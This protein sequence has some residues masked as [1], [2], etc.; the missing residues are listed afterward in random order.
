[1][2]PL[3]YFLLSGLL[4]YNVSCQTPSITMSTSLAVGNEFIFKLTGTA[5]STT[6]QVDFGSGFVNK[7]FGSSGTDTIKGILASSTIKLKEAEYIPWIVPMQI[8]FLWM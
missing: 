4:C 6:V 7:T 1:M 8:L 5:T 3:F 2:K